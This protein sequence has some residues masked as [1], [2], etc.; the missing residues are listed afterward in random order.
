[1]NIIADLKNISKNYG[2]IKALKD[3]NLKISKGETFALVGPNGSGKTTLLKILACID[4]PD[5]GDV[6]INGQKVE[7]KNRDRAKLN[8]TMVFQRTTLFS[9]SVSNNIAFGL[10]LRHLP[11]NE[12]EQAVKRTL[13]MVK[14]EGYENRSAKKLSGGEQQRVS[15]ARALAL[16]TPLLLLDEP[17]A[18]LDPKSASII[19]EVIRLVNRQGVTIVMATHNIFQAEQV[20]ERAA[21]L[22]DGEIAEVNTIEKILRRS[23]KLAKFNRLENVFSGSSQIV[24]GTSRIRL[25][26]GTTIEA[27]LRKNGRVTIFV[28]PE[29]IILSKGKFESSARNVF[30]GKIVD[31]SDKGSLVRLRIDAGNEFVVQITKKSFVE[32]GLN[33]G[34]LVYLTFKAS[35]VQLI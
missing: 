30:H 17:T 20:T 35:S 8:T 18:N 19:E 11:K 9:T 31:I 13:E 16:N 5:S 26:D 3:V 14:L 29:D 6:Y 1:M 33:M 27:A 23:T 12:I 32:M 24:E 21:L 25:D 28:R 10:K 22:I 4:E 7:R 15:L 2:T 34:S